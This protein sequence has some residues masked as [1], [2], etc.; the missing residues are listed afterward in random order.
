MVYHQTQHHSLV[1]STPVLLLLEADVGDGHP[2]GPLEG[3]KD[4]R[5]ALGLL[6]REAVPSWDRGELLAEWVDAGNEQNRAQVARSI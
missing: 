5:K 1:L 6:S 4:S 3:K 2:P